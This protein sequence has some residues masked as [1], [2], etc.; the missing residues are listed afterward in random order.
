[1][2]GVR[3]SH[4]KKVDGEDVA[5]YRAVRIVPNTS[6]PQVSPADRRRVTWL[7]RCATVVDNRRRKSGAFC[8]LP[9][10]HDHRRVVVDSNADDRV[11]NP[12]QGH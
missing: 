11:V 10:E 4:L 3:V 7:D 5:V 8:A 9:E 6:P 12:H 2:S 1:M